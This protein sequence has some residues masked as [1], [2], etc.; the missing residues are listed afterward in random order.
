MTGFF[1]GKRKRA[2]REAAERFARL[3][4]GD[5]TDELRA[6]YDDWVRSDLLNA[7]EYKKVEAIWSDVDIAKDAALSHL[8]ELELQQDEAPAWFKFRRLE[9]PFVRWPTVTAA[10]AAVLLVLTVVIDLQLSVQSTPSAGN[11]IV[12]LTKA[13]EHRSVLLDDGST[14]FL[15][16]QS[17]VK[18][19]MNAAR[20]ELNLL[21]GEALFEVRKDPNRPFVVLVQGINVT[22]VGTEF[23]VNLLG[24]KVDV[25]VIEGEV[26]VT[27]SPEAR[28]SASEAELARLSDGQQLEYQPDAG[29]SEVANIEVGQVLAWRERRLDFES[30][31]LEEVIIAL[32]R[33]YDSRFEVLAA[34]PVT[35]KVS[36]VFEVGDFDTTLKALDL[37]LPVR[38]ERKG[39]R[40]VQ[41]LA[42]AQ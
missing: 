14:L 36:G 9:A 13:G 4:D 29:V 20:R 42:D 2:Q 33:N 31:S 19:S 28:G 34:D 18:V 37:V 15:N 24:R 27:R 16:G 12:Y 10:A 35:L 11:E 3:N 7:L 22:A 32:E 17:R 41:I 26:L 6:D 38:F 5:V 1:G 39:E 21:E 30:A 8:K 23:N 40:L 25:T